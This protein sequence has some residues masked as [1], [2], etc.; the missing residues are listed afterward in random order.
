MAGRK[1]IEEKN[2]PT[3]DL[4]LSNMHG[5]GL[6]VPWVYTRTFPPL[7]FAV[8]VPLPPQ[9]PGLWKSSWYFYSTAR[10]CSG[11]HGSSCRMPSLPIPGGHPQQERL[12][13]LLPCR[14]PACP[15]HLQH[16]R[17]DPCI[18]ISQVFWISYPPAVPSTEKLRAESCR[19]K[20]PMNLKKSLPLNANYWGSGFS[21]CIW[22]SHPTEGSSMNKMS[23][24]WPIK[25]RFH[26]NAILHSLK[27]TFPLVQN[28]ICF[29]SSLNKYRR[30]SVVRINRENLLTSSDYWPQKRIQTICCYCCTQGSH[31]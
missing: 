6:G 27:G 29:W 23:N 26:S 14:K 5:H 4:K 30:V 3:K 19:K 25:V 24:I 12:G 9:S 2:T 21:H 16:V 17:E 13:S 31:S 1:V 7:S 22:M 20:I 8:V 11:K 28:K 15:R 10:W 18:K